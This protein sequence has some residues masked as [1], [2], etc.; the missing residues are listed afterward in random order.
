MNAAPSPEALALVDLVDFKWLMAHE[1]HPVHV[2]RLQRDP[3]YAQAQLA[4]A[5]ASAT[6]PLRRL[7]LSLRPRLLPA[8]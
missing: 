5:E 4:L 6:E 7:A 1:G 2:E 3:T 8:A